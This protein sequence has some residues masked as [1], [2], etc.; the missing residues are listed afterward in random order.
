MSKYAWAWDIKPEYADR[1]AEFHLNPWPEIMEA[2]RGAGIRNYSIFR[3][4]NQFLYV[5]ECDGPL[6]QAFAK[7]EGNEAVARW[8]AIMDE[9][10]V[11]DIGSPKKLLQEVFFLA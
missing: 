5:L 9:M 3:N 7:M 10:I 4:G 6:E 1:Y 11:G 2:H 8:D